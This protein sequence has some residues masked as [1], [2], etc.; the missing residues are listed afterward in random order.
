MV[1][2]GV[3]KQKRLLV[4]HHRRV[5]I[6]DVPEGDDFASDTQIVRWASDPAGRLHQISAEVPDP[7]EFPVFT[8]D[9]DDGVVFRF[10]LRRAN[11][12]LEKGSKRGR[13]RRTGPPTWYLSVWRRSETGET[14]AMEEQLSD[15]GEAHRRV[16]N[17]VKQ[18]AA[19]AL[20]ES[21]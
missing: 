16:D 6:D 15:S 20:N 3:S 7:V 18:V 13:Q 17:L 11:R 21:G 14:L 1:K 19:G 9:A 10:M 12:R 8:P 5:D 2:S 4:R